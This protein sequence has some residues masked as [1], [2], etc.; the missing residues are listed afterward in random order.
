[1][2]KDVVLGLINRLL[3]SHHG[4]LMP[5]MAGGMEVARQDPLLFGHFVTYNAERSRIKDSF[6]ALPVVGLF[7]TCMPDTIENCAAHLLKLNP[8]QLEKAV[9]FYR[10]LNSKGHTVVTGNGRIFK[11]TQRQYLRQLESDNGIFDNVVVN[12]RKAV[13][14]LYA[15]SHTAPSGRAKSILFD[16]NYPEGSVFAFVR[17]MHFLEPKVVAGNIA[18]YRLSTQVITGAAGTR[19]ITE[20]ILF[21]MIDGM[22]PSELVN[23][24]KFIRTRAGEN[25]VIMAAF[26]QGLQKAAKDKRVSA[27]KISKAAKAAGGRVA[28]QLKAVEEAV[29]DS[30]VLPGKWLILGDASGSMSSAVKAATDIA[31]AI[32][33]YAEEVHLVFFNTAP[34]YYNV[35][36]K[37]M[38]EINA[39]CSGVRAGGGTSIGCGVQYMTRKGYDVDAIV[40]ISD[41]Q[42][43]RAPGFLTE[44]RKMKNEPDVYYIK[45]GSRP[46][47]AASFARGLPVTEF[48]G[49]QMDYYSF[50][51]L[52]AAMSADR[53]KIF[54][55][56][57]ES[58]LWTRDEVLNTRGRN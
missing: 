8:R 32:A 55:D 31:G 9:R 40:L 57:M 22:T 41:G 36:G 29:F 30:T 16:K 47:G 44:Y 19:G 5:Y 11:N 1:M 26:E 17:D 12:N 27:H 56:I 38:D 14:A 18:R 33:R 46:T 49:K 50:P 45:L 48:D 4:D 37:T 20:G 23:Y 52:V 10:A 34:K 28:K 53:Y 51:N 54:D 58:R 6:T 25:E 21:A 7:S 13:T 15:L 35:S 42:E 3:G 24:A 2:E 43:N 39:I